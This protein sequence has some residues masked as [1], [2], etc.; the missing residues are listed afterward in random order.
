MSIVVVGS[1]NQDLVVRTA[2]HPLPGETVL[3]HRHFAAAGGKGGNQAVAAARLGG[4]VTMV[5][6]VGN[7]QP[8]TA[9][10]AALAA[11][12]ID[13]GNVTVDGDVGTGLAVI[14][15]DEAAEN[16]IVVSAGANATLTADHVA[17]ASEP[18]AAATV[19]LVQLEIPL[20]AVDQAMVLAGGKVILNPAPAVALPK[21]LLGRVSV[22]VPN[23]SELGVLA[24]R[25]E[26]ASIDEVGEAART[27]A[28]P[29]S[30]VVTLGGDGALLVHEG[31]LHHVPAPD[32]DPIDTVGAGDAFCAALADAVT[33]DEDLL[34][35]TRWAVL[36]GAAACLRA[37]A[38]PSM[39]TPDDVEALR[40]SSR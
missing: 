4:Q 5:G 26:P 28:G 12:G 35:A 39:P 13:V 32:I 9:L 38:Q 22:L 8:G 31:E 10:V 34:N 1:I 33:R 40:D 3:G 25:A 2:R 17:A 36:A 7:D 23:R 24:G 16:T 20:D 29:A 19:T 18:L 37:G 27:L 14:T 6:R 21:A 30:V 11:E 15:L